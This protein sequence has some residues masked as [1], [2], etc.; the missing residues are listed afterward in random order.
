MRRKHYTFVAIAFSAMLSSTMEAQQ[1][2][3]FWDE[4]PGVGKG[5]VLQQ[6]TGTT[7]SIETELD[8]SAFPAG[9]HQLGLRVLNDTYFSATYYRSF[10]VPEVEE[11]ITRIEY[12]WDKDV[13]L[14]SG[15]ALPFNPGATIDLTQDLSAS[16]LSTGMHTL[17][18]RAIST[19]HHS[20]TYTRSFYVPPTAYE[21]TAIEYFF[22]VDPGVG[23]GTQMTA[24]LTDGELIKAF[25]VDTDGLADGVHKIGLR[26]LTDGTWS[27][28]YYRQFLV[29][30]EADNFITRVEYFWNDDPGEGNG[31]VVDITPGEEVNMEFEADMFGLAQGNHT[32]GLRAQSWTGGWSTPSLTKNIEFE[33]WD[34]L[35]A[36]LNSLIDTEDNFASNIYERQYLNKEWHA[37]YVP[38]SLQYSDWAAHFDVARINAFYQYDD[39]EDGIVDRQ[40]LEAIIVKP[41]NGSLKPNYPYLI[42]PKTT[43]TY[44]LTVP[45]SR[46]VAKAI[47]SVS[48][49]TLEAEYTFTGNYSD[50]TGLKSAQRYRLRGGS[51]SIPD[52]DDEVLPPFRWYLT[53]EDLGNQLDPAAGSRIAI[54]VVGE[55]EATGLADTESFGSDA[56]REVYDLQGRKV[57][58]RSSLKSGVYIINNKKC[59]V[60]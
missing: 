1:V 33:G 59:V 44:S 3:Y 25:D 8:V 4:D 42:R 32:L 11:E 19:N 57:S 5:Q 36:Y 46:Q 45:A 52:N 31:Y 58:T 53:V 34:A 10:Y 48:C 29:R 26:T 50:L 24:C 38:F 47:N 41:A 13:P 20:L 17:Y 14:G 7:A 15:I 51:L 9:I 43:G 28:T 35:Q 37:L 60:K 2:E 21:V 55:D 22:D 54:S 16:G 39:N 23:R 56:P 6:F 30:T 18:L 27:A 12:F 40:V 49:S